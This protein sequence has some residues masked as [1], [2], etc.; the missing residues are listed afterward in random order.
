MTQIQATIHS[1]SLQLSKKDSSRGVSIVCTHDDG[2]QWGKKIYQWLWWGDD[3]YDST[4][5][6]WARF[7]DPDCEAGNPAKK[8]VASHDLC[9]IELDLIVDTS[10]NFWKILNARLR[11]TL[12]EQESSGVIDDDIPF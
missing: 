8:I 9:G 4:I 12:E 1:V 11:G 7:Y 6:V 5:T 3:S 10:E 2:S